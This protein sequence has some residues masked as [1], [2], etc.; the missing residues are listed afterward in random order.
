MSDVFPEVTSQVELPAVP[1][2]LCNKDSYP[3][4]FTEAVSK[5]VTTEFYVRLLSKS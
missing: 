1:S 5:H 4:L 2:W 3:R